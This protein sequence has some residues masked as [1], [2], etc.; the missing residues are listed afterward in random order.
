MP[1]VDIAYFPTLFDQLTNTLSAT[2]ITAYIWNGSQSTDW[3]TIENWTPTGNPSSSTAVIIPNAANT[4]N[5]PVLPIAASVLSM[6]L[7]QGSVLN[8]ASNAILNIHGSTGAWINEG[9]VFIPSTSKVVFN[10][11]SSS[12]AGHTT[13]Y[14]LEVEDGASL[15]MTYQLPYCHCR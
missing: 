10:A 2:E 5:D 13:F 12:V 7:E 14:D 3:A 11:N 6:K 4:V 9:G 15:S 8:G 1:N